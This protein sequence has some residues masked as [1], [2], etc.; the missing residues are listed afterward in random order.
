[1]YLGGTIDIM[2]VHFILGKCFMTF[3]ISEISFSTRF[4]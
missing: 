4:F 3:D 1:M 2:L